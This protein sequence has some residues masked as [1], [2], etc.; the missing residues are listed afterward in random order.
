MSAPEELEAGEDKTS[1]AGLNIFIVE[2]GDMKVLVGAYP[3]LP[4]LKMILLRFDEHP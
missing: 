1:V 3:G 2:F 4:Q